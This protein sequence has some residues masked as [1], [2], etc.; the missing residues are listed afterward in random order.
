M[1]IGYIIGCLF[2]ILLWRV[3]RQRI[4]NFINVKS[5]DKINNIYVLQ[6]LY[7][8]LIFIIYLGLVFIKNNQVYNAITAFIVIDI[9]NTERKNLKNNEK[10]YFY[11]TISS[12]TR[13]LICGFITPLFLIIMFG[14]GL[15]IVFTILYNLSADE[16]LNLLG[17]IVSIANIIPSI[18]AEVFLYII[19]VFRKRNLKIK[20]KGDYISNLFI[21]PLLNVDIL[22]AFIES[23]NFYS[24]H[25][26]NNMHYLKYYGDYNNKIDNVCIKD[27]LSI[28]YSI[29]FLVFIA[30]LVIQLI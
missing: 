22:A 21:V 17:F 14:N 27:Y 23:V 2:S 9:S 24:Y 12:I 4:F 7:L 5:K 28:S 15:A 1:G 19:Y 16:D 18:I 13:A 30:F 29:C 11:D 26:G 3:D 10:K 20:F 6:F 8:F 25:N